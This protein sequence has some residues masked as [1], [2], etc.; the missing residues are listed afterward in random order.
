MKENVNDRRPALETVSEVYLARWD[1]AAGE[2]G[3]E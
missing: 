1:S 2:L 3:K